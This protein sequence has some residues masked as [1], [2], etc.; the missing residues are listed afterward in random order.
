MKFKEDFLWGAATA[1]YQVEGAAYEDGKGLSIW[2]VFCEKPGRILNGHTGEVACDQ[3]HRYE[4]DVKMMADMGIQ[5]Y[6]FS[7]SW[8]RIM[9]KGTGEINPAGIAY[10]NHLID[11]LLKYNIKPYVTLY[12]WD[13][14][15][16]LHKK[17]G[18]LNEEIVEWFGEYAKVV[19][20]N[21]SDRVE[22]FFTVNEPQCF[23]GISYMGTQHAPGYGGTIREGLQAGHN[24][25][26]AH[27]RAVQMLRK[28]A[29][30]EIKVGFAPTGAFTYPKSNDEKDVE[31]AK[32]MMFK[33]ITQDN[34]VWNVAWWNDPVYL[35]QYPKEGLEALAAYL[36]EITS[37]DME[38][39]HQPL[40]FIGMNI[41][42]GQMV[43]ADD[44]TSWKLEER[45]IGFPQTGMK[46][47]ITPEVLYWAPKFLCE[48]YKKPIYITENG[49]AS[50]DMIAADGKI[51][52]ENRIAF[53]DQYLHY[54]RKAS[55][56]DIPVAGYFVWSLMD[57][58][59]WAFGYTE[60]FGIVYV[61]YT[62]QERT[63]KESGKWYKKVIISD[64]NNRYCIEIPEEGCIYI[65]KE[66]P[67]PELL[68]NLLQ[69]ITTPGNTMNEVRKCFSDYAVK[70]H[71]TV[72]ENASEE[73][74]MGHVFS[75]ADP[76]V[77]EYCYCVEENEFGLTY[78]RFSREDYQAL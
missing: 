75:F 59:E 17:G 37:E 55:D 63:I 18:W 26:K 10:Y 72:R 13:L 16:E 42:N 36:P 44:Q 23:I 32:N 5:A 46:W 19:A 39:I 78:H 68:Q 9:P 15:Y 76:S 62:S 47:P 24:A 48:R 34:W 3:Y 64:N 29:K 49:L 40:D 67:V 65:E 54:Y 60:R 74:E 35:G 30:S 21:F 61:D 70:M 71:T 20:E 4:E 53:L 58:F 77:D 66:I 7:L 38:L 45:Y 1:S 56:E 43:S 69:V 6:R 57:N 52:D 28:Y 50:P 22:N 73:H 11:C 27:G 14:P 8:P 31:A 12:H 33:N 41:Y 25:L 51:H 2:D